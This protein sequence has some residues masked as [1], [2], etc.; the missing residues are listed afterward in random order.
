[1]C[2]QICS[3]GWRPIAAD[4]GGGMYAHC[5]SRLQFNWPL[6]RAIDEAHDLLR[7]HSAQCQLAASSNIA[8]HS[9]SR[10]TSDLAIVQTFTFALN[11]ILSPA[12]WPAILV[13]CLIL[14]IVLKS[15]LKFTNFSFSFSLAA[16]F[17]HSFRFVDDNCPIFVIVVVILTKTNWRK[18][19]IVIF[20]NASFRYCLRRLKRHCYWPL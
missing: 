17:R 5:T 19:I 13:T 7:Y 12:Y 15:A 14:V 1:M 2:R 20:V 18:L 8:K 11:T 3:L 4:W 16:N 6:M 9:R 10:L